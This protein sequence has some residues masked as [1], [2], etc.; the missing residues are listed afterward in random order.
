MAVRADSNKECG[1]SALGGPGQVAVLY[2]LA[3]AAG[4]SGVPNRLSNDM[5]KW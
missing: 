5:L 4:R 3:E 2:A 1:W